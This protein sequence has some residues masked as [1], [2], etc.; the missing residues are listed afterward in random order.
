MLDSDVNHTI[1]E[2]Y[3]KIVLTVPETA[4]VSVLL[5]TM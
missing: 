5:E 1:L 3:T 2:V 4:A